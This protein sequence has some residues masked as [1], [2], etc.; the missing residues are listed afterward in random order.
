[1]KILQKEK[2][3]HEYLLLERDHP[4]SLAAYVGVVNVKTI[5]ADNKHDNIFF[6]LHTPFLILM[7]S[8]LENIALYPICQDIFLISL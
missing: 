6:M 3:N 1:M 8:N 2:T 7:D 5:I 4:L